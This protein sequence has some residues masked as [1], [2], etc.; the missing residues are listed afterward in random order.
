MR[1]LFRHAIEQSVRWAFQVDLYADAF[2]RLAIFDRSRLL[3]ATFQHKI[4][5]ELRHHPLLFIHVPKNG[6]TSLKRSLY[7]HDPGHSTVR[8][9]DWLE[10]SLRSSAVCFAL[11]R[12]PVER[13][14]S[15]FDFLMNGGG[16]DVSIQP[17]ARRRLSKV[18]SVDQF[19][20]YLESINGDWFKVDTFARPQW[21]YI[22][23][24]DG[25]IAIDHLWVIG[26]QDTEIS[27]LLNKHGF[28]SPS[29]ANR[30]KRVERR[31]S[32]QQHARVE[33]LY[34]PDFPI[35]D[36][37]SRQLGAGRNELAAIK[38]PQV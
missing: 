27:A 2:E 7:A 8:Y 10:P 9:Y 3:S 4:A 29:H 17:A 33:R 26:E 11:I 35:Y 37:V 24:R 16:S 13:F 23:D 21:W 25:R 28:P 36:A 6:G 20:D 38:V 15:S 22:A 18:R 30:T 19:L 34:G 1:Q 5:Q 31:L 14:L 32:P 12:N